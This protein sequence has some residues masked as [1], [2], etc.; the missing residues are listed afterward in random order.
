VRISPEARFIQLCV[1]EPLPQGSIE[2]AARGVQ[3]WQYVVQLAVRHR[4][5]AYILNSGVELPS[6]IAAHLRADVLSARAV[7][8]LLDAELQR[9]GAAFQASGL[10]VI[11]LKGPALARELYVDPGLRPYADLDLTIH[12]EH[13]ERAIDALV[14]SGYR[15]LEYDSETLR[16]AH[17]GHVHGSGG[18]HR[19][20]GGANG[21]AL[22]ELHLDPLQLGVRST[23]EV[24]R[25]SRAIPIRALGGV[26]MLGIE[27]QVVQLSVH[28][29]KHG[30]SRLIWLKDLDLLLRLRAQALDW[31]LVAHIARRE[32]VCAS[33]WYALALTGMMLGTQLPPA[34]ARLRPSPA[35]RLL[36]GWVWRK[37]RIVNLEGAMRRRGVQ[38]HAADS[39]RGMLPSLVLMGRRSARARLLLHAVLRGTQIS[40]FT[41]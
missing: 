4:V 14:A 25:W 19:L 6:D 27:D 31:D 18:F 26:L 28:A 3:D 22:I 35:L 10:P 40:L 21:R 38:F 24:E 16:R 41:H 5:A 11:A 39:W 2:Q 12:E 15:E 32:G 7:A 34:V 29:H 23:C 13:E 9:V 36:Y 33:V 37:E 8:L 20:F 30:F 1:R 17:L